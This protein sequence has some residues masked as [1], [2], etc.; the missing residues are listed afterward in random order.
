MIS[1]TVE[2]GDG[3]NYRGWLICHINKPVARLQQIYNLYF[4]FDNLCS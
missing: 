2:E 3:H 1:N 4:L